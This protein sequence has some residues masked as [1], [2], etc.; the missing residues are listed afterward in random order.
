MMLARPIT[1]AAG[2][3]RSRS[4]AAPRVRAV[5]AMAKYTVYVKGDPKTSTLLDC[6]FCH[7]VLLTL[8]TKGIHYDLRHID[9][10]DKPQ[11]LVEKFDGKVPVLEE[12]DMQMNDS[13]KIVEWLEEKM[14][15]PAM[16][17]ETPEAAAKFLPAFR[18]Y[19][20]AAPEEAEDKK[21]AWMGALDTLEAAL[22]KVP[23][24]LFGGASLN[25][26]DAALAPKVYHAFTALKHFRGFDL[27]ALPGNAYPAIK[28]YRLALAE[29]PAWKKTDYG[30]EAIIKG[31]ERHGAKVQ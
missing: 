14:P 15:T 29:L 31:W 13:D 11:W 9:F 2:S 4:S 24:P 16:K 19:L 1:K 6:P 21:A 22:A 7:R 18:G 8:E 23:G 20:M 28:K 5:R 30:Q 10:A 17:A 27:Y 26:V 12:G 3:I 25:A